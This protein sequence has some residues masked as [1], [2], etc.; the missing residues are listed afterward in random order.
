MNQPSQMDEHGAYGPASKVYGA[1]VYNANGDS[2]YNEKH[3]TRPP[4]PLGHHFV[5]ELPNE[6]TPGDRATGGA[7]RAELPMDATRAELSPV[8]RTGDGGTGFVQELDGAEVGVP[9]ALRTRNLPGSPSP[10]SATKSQS[11]KTPTSTVSPLSPTAELG[12]LDC[13]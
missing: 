9:L 8:E 5:S 12:R 11:P 1:S 2:Y 7:M 10:R 13:A 3:S 4:Y 6:K